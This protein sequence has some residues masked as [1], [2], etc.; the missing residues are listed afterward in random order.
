MNF[1]I[2]NDDNSVVTDHTS[3][4]EVTGDD[5]HHA[6]EFSENSTDKSVSDLNHVIND[7]PYDEMCE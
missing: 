1:V 7:T 4:C 3:C 5:D 2:K 6:S